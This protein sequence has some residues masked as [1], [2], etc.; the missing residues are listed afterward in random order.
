MQRAKKSIRSKVALKEMLIRDLPELLKED[1]LLK[2]YVASLFKENFADKRTT[3]EE[4]KAL[5]EEIKNLRIESEK[6]WEEHSQ[7]LKEHSKRFEEHSKR[8]EEQS[9]I[10]KEHSKRLEEQSQI[11]KEHSKRLE[12]HS[13]ILKEHSK[14]LE[15]HSQK[16]EELS[17]GNK[18]LMEE[19]LALRKRQDVQIGALGARWGIKSE[20][21]FR[22]AVKGLLEETFG[23]KVEHYETTDLEGEVFEGFPGKTVEID[24]II[25]DG[26][27]IVAEIKSS[28]SPADVLLFERKVKFFEKKEGR[29]VTRKIII[30]P[31]IDREAKNF[32]KSL[33][34]TFY[35]DVPDRE[36][37]L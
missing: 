4:I 11:L 17:Q 29:R 10:L 6:R 23:V 2:D 26:E 35:T 25:R 19:I 7:I 3:E 37:G 16:L 24:L 21:T 5:L 18:I 27:L 32:C 14:R 31:M 30:S 28:V 33:G 1:P 34:I 9:Q 13:Q 20:K 15:E 12:E 36:A 8:F 22:N